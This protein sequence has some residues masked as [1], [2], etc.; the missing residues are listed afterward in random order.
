MQ[1]IPND[2]VVV[3]QSFPFLSILCLIFVF[4]KLTG[5]IS[6]SWWLVFAPVWV[7]FAMVLGIAVI[8]VIIACATGSFKKK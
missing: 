8:I 2:K 4:C 6:W 7:P 3:K 1:N 5:Y